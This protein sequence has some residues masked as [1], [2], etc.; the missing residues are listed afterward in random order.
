MSHICRVKCHS[1]EHYQM[2]GLAAGGIGSYTL[3][4]C[5]EILEASQDDEDLRECTGGV[6]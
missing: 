5:G 2:Y 6:K 1:S 4:E 3:C